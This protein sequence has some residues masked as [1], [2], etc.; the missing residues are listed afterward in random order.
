LLSRG[1]LDFRRAEQR[2]DDTGK[3]L[4]QAVAGALDVAA[5]VIGDLRSG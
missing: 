2:L 3:F 1:A 5:V 4:Q